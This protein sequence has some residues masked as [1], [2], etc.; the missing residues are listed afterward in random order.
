MRKYLATYGNVSVYDSGFR[1]P[2][3]GSGVDKTG[4]DWLN[5]ALDQG[6]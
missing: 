3:Y 6:T 4:Q 5:I 2:Y 1:L